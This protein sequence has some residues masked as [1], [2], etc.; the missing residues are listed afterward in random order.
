MEFFSSFFKVDFHFFFIN[1]DLR[2]D[3]YLQ[4]LHDIRTEVSKYNLRVL[5][6]HVSQEIFEAFSQVFVDN[7]DC[8][9]PLACLVCMLIFSPSSH[10]FCVFFL[11]I[12]RFLV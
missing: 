9:F 11:L 10:L 6:N 1:F 5:T 12:S 8:D 3:E 4:D 2:Q 7:F